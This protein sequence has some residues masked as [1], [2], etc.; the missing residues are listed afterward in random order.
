MW[1][2]NCLFAPPYAANFVRAP[3]DRDIFVGVSFRNQNSKKAE[4]RHFRRA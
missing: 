4:A 1:A 3:K 2:G